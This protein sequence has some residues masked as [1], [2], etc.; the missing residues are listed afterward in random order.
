MAD[1]NAAGNWAS[2][3]ATILILCFAIACCCKAKGMSHALVDTFLGANL[4][5]I[6]YDIRPGLNHE[7]VFNVLHFG[8][9]PDGRKDS[10]QVN[11][12][13]CITPA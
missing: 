12:N 9:N 13:S 6:T 11:I 5:R 3:H 4:R 8:A 7:K 2:V 10:T 1:N